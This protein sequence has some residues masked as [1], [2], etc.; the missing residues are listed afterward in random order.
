MSSPAP[1][2]P[3]LTQVQTLYDLLTQGKRN[4]A[5]AI[6]DPLSRSDSQDAEFC[7]GLGLISLKLG[8]YSRAVEFLNRALQSAPDN[9]MLLDRLGA[10]YLLS[11]RYYLAQQVLR[12]ALDIDPNYVSSLIHLG[13][14]HAELHQFNKAIFCYRRAIRLEPENTTLLNNLAFALKNAGQV[15]EAVEIIKTAIKLNPAFHHA[16]QT[17]GTLYSELGDLAS[18]TEAFTEAIRLHP[19]FGYAYTGLAQVK[20]FTPEDQPLLDNIEQILRTSL[21]PENRGCMH[22]CLGKAYDDLKQWNKAFTHYRQAN[23]LRFAMEVPPPYVSLRHLKTLVKK[24]LSHPPTGNPSQAPVFVLGMPRSGS[25]L[26]DQ[27]ISAHPLAETAGEMGTMVGVIAHPVFLPENKPRAEIEKHFSATALQ[28]YAEIYLNKLFEKRENAKRIVDKTPSNFL[29]LGYI[30]LMFPNARII[31]TIRHPLDTTLSCYFQM[32]DQLP[33]ANDLASIA[34]TYCFYRETMAHWH[35][36]FPGRIVDV[37]YEQLTANPEPESRRLI[38]ACGLDWDPACLEYFKQ[39]NR[40]STAS[41]WQVRQ[42]IYQTSKQ[43]WVHYAAHLE[44]LAQGMARYLSEED[45][46]IFRQKGIKLGTGRNFFDR[47]TTFK[48]FDHF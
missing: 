30:L 36:Q 43:R 35:Q 14:L 2:P 12:R 41:L 24:H 7:N 40:V 46:E 20:K 22:H 9:L 13:S 48:R 25:T 29:Y 16:H 4:E 17:L 19:T 15:E 23:L 11:K 5:L 47:I 6:Y 39:E 10:A 28:D 34:E 8:F 38:E 27:I 42:P 26:V 33:W 32:F 21:E 31:H 44:P 1:V 3:H 18:A 37:H 45:R